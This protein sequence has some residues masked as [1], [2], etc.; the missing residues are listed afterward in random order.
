[1]IT[2]IGSRKRP[3]RPWWAI[4]VALV[5][6]GIAIAWVATADRGE[7]QPSASF[8]LTF[9]DPGPS[10]ESARRVLDGHP[11]PH[12]LTL[13]DQRGAAYFVWSIKT[14]RGAPTELQADAQR[15]A[16]A[17]RTALVSGHADGLE[18]PGFARSLDRLEH[19]GPQAC[20]DRTS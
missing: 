12:D 5:L 6:L 16:R 4:V 14:A 8:C 11:R 9:E 20:R 13:D 15:V 3:S 17:M 10:V 7:N 1:M 18:D 19:A 2:T